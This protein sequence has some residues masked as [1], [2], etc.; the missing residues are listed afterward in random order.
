MKNIWFMLFAVL[1]VLQVLGFIH[2]WYLVFMPLI[3][4]LTIW[5]VILIPL[6]CVGVWMYFKGEIDL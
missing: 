1:F 3:I 5:A 4:W 2:S 6:I